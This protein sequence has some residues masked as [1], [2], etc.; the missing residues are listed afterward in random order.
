MML[1]L[2][3]KLKNLRDALVAANGAKTYH[4]FRPRLEAPYLIWAEM[5][6][7]RS[8]GSNNHKDA[9]TIQG[10]IDYFTKTEFD[11][12]VDKI[13]N[14]VNGVDG[15]AWKLNSVQFEEETNLIHYEWYFWVI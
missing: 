4:Y 3:D 14:A 15:I 5:T 6:E 12:A 10:T 11:E 2:Q 13:Q 7:D 8:A 1:S 9:Q